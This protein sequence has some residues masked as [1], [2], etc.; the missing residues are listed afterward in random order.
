MNSSAADFSSLDAGSFGDME[1]KAE[2][3][4]TRIIFVHRD[5]FYIL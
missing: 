5:L 2:P 4:W 1:L 3:R